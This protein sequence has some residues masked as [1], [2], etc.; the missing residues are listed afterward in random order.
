MEKEKLRKRIHVAAGRTPADM[1]IR[2]G[3]VVNVFSGEIQEQSVA[4]CDGVIAGVGDYRGKKEIDAGGCYILPGL[5][6][7]HI[8]I[9]SSFVTPEEVGRLLI[10]HGTTTI[11]ADPHEIVNVAGMEGLRYMLD[12]AENTPLDIKYMLPSCVPCTP[13]EHSGAVLNGADMELPVQEKQILGLGEFMNFTGV[14]QAEDE[15][16]EKLLVAKHAGKF[17]DGHCPGLGGNALNAYAAAG[18]HTDHECSTVEELQERINKGMYV[19]LR[20][21]SACHD[22]AK[23]LRGVT[24]VNSRRCVLCSDDRQP[25][26]IF[27]EGHLD[28]H[29]KI[30]V[31][32]GIDPVMAIQMATI[33]AAECYGLA[34]RGAIVPGRRADLVLVKDLKTFQAEQ[35]FIE[36][37]LVAENGIYL[38]PVVR[39]AIT[40]VMGSVRVQDFSVDRLKMK[41]KSN[42]VKT[43]GVIPGGIVTEKKS[44][45]VE[46]DENGDFLYNPEK[47]VCKIAVVERHHGTGSMAVGLLSGYGIQKGAVGISVSHDSHHIIVAGTNNQD[48]VLAVNTIIEQQGGAALVK[49]G[50]VLNTMPLP[51]GGIMS[52]QS[53]EWVDRKLVT[54]HRA[55]QEELGVNPEVDPLMTLC[56]MA[57]PV[58]PELKMTDIG[59]FDVTKFQFTSI[60]EENYEY[61]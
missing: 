41:L 7:S 45:E 9:E 14:I 40:P 50:N 34:D 30:C 5:I 55:A 60:E 29:L 51:V 6:D 12:A 48:I 49:E 36:G 18:I 2:N 31:E 16:L 58:I 4:I 47:D 46:L 56:F 11:I 24:A 10:P 53:G 8:H 35:V 15:I 3:K 23:L 57:L 1:V 26:T 37:N 39:K 59:L 33:N 13:F 44:V 27:E 20:Q 32:E 61:H 52:D 17:I 54:M 42:R 22:L 28:G 21:G 38:R 25:K 43:I 19:Q